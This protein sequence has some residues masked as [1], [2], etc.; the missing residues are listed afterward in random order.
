MLYVGRYVVIKHCMLSC[1]SLLNSQLEGKCTVTGDCMSYV[2]IRWMCVSLSLHLSPSL[3]LCLPLPPCCSEV[4]MKFDF[5]VSCRVLRDALGRRY[6][7]R[8]PSFYGL[9]HQGRVLVVYT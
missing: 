8:N 4:E 3:S 2:Y 6:G 9:R 1:T 7:V 5:S